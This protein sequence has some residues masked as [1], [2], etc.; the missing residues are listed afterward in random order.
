MERQIALIDCNNFYASCERVFNPQLESK[1][2]V[3][4]SNNDGCIIARSAEAK[5]LGIKMGDNYF[6][7]KAMLEKNKVEVFSSNYQLY[8]D[9][10]KRVMHTLS[11]FSPDLE[12]YSIDEAFVELTHLYELQKKPDF[13]SYSH[14]MRN[15]VR[16][17]TGIPVSVGI[18]PSKTL[19]KLANRK[20]K[21]NK[22]SDGVLHL[23]EKHAIK[24][25]LSETEVG[26]VWGIGF[27]YADMLSRNGYHSAYDFTQAPENWVR[28]KMSVVGLR[29]W[30]EL[31][32]FACIP[33]Q[34]SVPSEEKKVAKKNICTSRSF[35]KAVTS[36]G[37][38]GEAVSYF[39][40]NA[41]QKLRKQHSCAGIITVFIATN[42]F[43]ETKPHYSKSKTVALPF[44]VR[45]TAMLT[46]YALSALE[47]VFEP[48][49]AYKKAGIMLSGIVSDSQVQQDLFGSLESKTE[50]LSVMVDKI[51]GRFG[52]GSI[53]LASEGREKLWQMKRA[54]LS[55][56]YTT[57]WK[58]MLSIAI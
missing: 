6:Q 46:K 58:D 26:D 4:L 24:K 29:T 22:A 5:A 2:V 16:K 41:S 9:M 54:F 42:R 10:S 38:L 8:G 31:Q 27:Q 15:T 32:G 21:K 51:N 18:A 52:K 45:T 23:S 48:G 47:S 17:N 19:A 57:D 7:V 53:F 13:E 3:V 11:D 37:E 43:D 55:P 39:I 28:K 20:A 36:L 34:P 44:P 14:R 30:Y 56:C 49:Y 12:V 25:V 35:G 33:F 40:S 50:I 1:P